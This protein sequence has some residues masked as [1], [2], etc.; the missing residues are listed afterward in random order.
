MNISSIT[1][2]LYDNEEADWYKYRCVYQGGKHFVEEYLQKVSNRETDDDF[3][4]RKLMTYAP[5]FAK[6]AINEIKNVIYNRL[7]DIVRQTE[8]DTYNRASMG[9]LNGVDNRGSSM[10]YFIGQNVTPEMLTMRRVG[11]YVDMAPHVPTTLIERERQPI[12]PYLY[13]YKTEEIKSWTYREPYETQEFQRILLHENTIQYDK[14]CGL[15]SGKMERYRLVWIGE[16]GYVHVKFFDDNDKPINISGDPEDREYVLGIKEIPFVM[17]EIPESLLKDAADYQIALLN[18][19]SSDVKYCIESNFPFYIEQFDSNINSAD[20]IPS[21]SDTEEGTETTADLIKAKTNEARVGPTYGRQYPQNT[22]PPAFIHPS[23]E[24]LQAAMDKEKQIK[25]DIKLL[26]NLSV[27]DL[28]DKMISADSKAMDESGKQTGL[29]CIAYVLERGERKIAK[30]WG[31]YEGITGNKITINYPKDYDLKSDE[32]RV[33]DCNDLYELIE[34]IP[35]IT[36]KKEILKAIVARL[37]YNKV[38]LDIRNKINKEIDDAPCVITAID[39]IISL[40]TIGL[41]DDESASQ[42]AGCKKGLVE[43]AKQDHAERLARIQAA[44]GD[45]GGS[46]RGVPDKQGD[47]KSSSDEKKGKPKRGP[48]K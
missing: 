28:S 19:E 42:A 45:Q 13:L 38:P 31:L 12:H 20:D 11:V 30:Y 16:D 22:N 17:F 37:L 7:R 36:F 43:K 26:V 34:R 2:P 18:I 23:S 4:R 8:S 29:A 32:E 15:P 25:K 5:S 48:A 10:D 40:Q 3:C 46:A 33:K 6:A 39:Q 44:Q 21:I 9:E 47:Q 27:A 24:P 14:E 1:H 35:S 41:I